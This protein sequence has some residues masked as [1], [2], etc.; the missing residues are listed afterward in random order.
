MTYE[1]NKKTEFK[2]NVAVISNMSF[3]SCTTLGF[4]H[5]NLNKGL[6]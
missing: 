2:I 1:G 4:C 3:S 5:R 6:L